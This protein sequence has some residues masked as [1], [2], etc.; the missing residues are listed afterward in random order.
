[1]YIISTLGKYCPPFHASWIFYYAKVI[2]L[3]LIP[4][5]NLHIARLDVFSCINIYEIFSS[6]LK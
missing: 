5:L 4:V 2:K 1:M 6:N 3:R